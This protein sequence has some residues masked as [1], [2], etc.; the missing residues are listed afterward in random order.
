MEGTFV[1]A[2]CLKKLK[3]RESGR[4]DV[5]DLV[6]SVTILPQFVGLTLASTTVESIFRSLFLKI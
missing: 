2:P 6:S 1:D 4:N 5:P 3:Q